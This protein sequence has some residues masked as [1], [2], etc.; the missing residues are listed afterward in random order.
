MRYKLKFAIALIPLR[1]L[2]VEGYLTPDHGGKSSDH[3]SACKTH[4]VAAGRRRARPCQA[5]PRQY[6]RICIIRDVSVE[7]LNRARI[8][9]IEV[10]RSSPQL[11]LYVLLSPSFVTKRTPSSHHASCSLEWPRTGVALVAG[12]T[13]RRFCGPAQTPSPHRC[14]SSRFRLRSVSKIGVVNV[15]DELIEPPTFG[16]ERPVRDN[17]LAVR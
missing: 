14:S 12:N 4:S 15:L 5:G 9:R 11:D 6:S 3:E 8:S 2:A 16:I 7:P 17:Q 1:A 13:L 10:I